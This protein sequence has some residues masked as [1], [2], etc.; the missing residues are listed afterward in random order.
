MILFAFTTLAGAA[1]VWEVRELPPYCVAAAFSSE[2]AVLDDRGELW[3]GNGRSDWRRVVL[4]IDEEES[5]PRRPTVTLEGP[6]LAVSWGD[7]T[8][9]SH[10]GGASWLSGPRSNGLE[11]SVEHP[12]FRCEDGRWWVRAEGT[13]KNLPVYRLPELPKVGVPL[14]AVDLW[15]RWDEREERGSVWSVGVGLRWNG[16]EL[17]GEVDRQRVDQKRLAL[18][19]ERARRI[20]P[21][22]TPDA[23]GPMAEVL[24]ELHEEEVSALEQIWMAPP[25]GSGR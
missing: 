17:R 10:D 6:D 19:R 16:G 12:E 21:E 4:P 20:L 3:L 18:L 1:P 25:L 23:H 5:V 14:P 7:R 2:V 11:R 15:F 9:V 8:F 22:R 13:A 24:R